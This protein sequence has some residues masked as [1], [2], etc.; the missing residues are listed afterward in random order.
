MIQS[1]E[2]KPPGLE[3]VEEMLDFA[4]KRWGVTIRQ[5]PHWV[6]HKVLT[7]SLYN[8]G[9]DAGTLPKWDLRDIYTIAALEAGSRF[10][11][12]GAKRTDSIWR[13]RQLGKQWA[14]VVYPIVGWNKFDVLSYLEMHKLP[15]PASSGR[16]ATG[17]D[18]ST[19]SLLWLHDT[20]PK[21]FEKVRASFPYVQAV[22]E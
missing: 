20:Y 22:V 7:G 19:P 2:A 6:L 15:I 1:F 16:A 21:D 8:D 10:V 13:R 5:Y 3:C 17:V 12:T 11:V 18:L 4:R 9:V 14:D